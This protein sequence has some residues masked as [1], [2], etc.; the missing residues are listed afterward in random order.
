M[1]LKYFI[2]NKKPFIRMGYPTK[3]SFI[4]RSVVFIHSALISNGHI[5]LNKIQPVPQ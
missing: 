1:L 2:Q 3:S 4:L 5:P